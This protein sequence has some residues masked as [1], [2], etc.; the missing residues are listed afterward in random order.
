MRRRGTPIDPAMLARLS[1]PGW[2]RINLTSDYVWSD[3][4]DLDANGLMPMLASLYRES[5]SE[6]CTGAFLSNTDHLH[7]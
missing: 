3:R 7:Q 1:R 6:S 5:V 2:D 4:L